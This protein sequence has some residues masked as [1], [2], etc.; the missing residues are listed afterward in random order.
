MFKFLLLTFLIIQTSFAGVGDIT[1]GQS[2]EVKKLLRKSHGIKGDK[3]HF[4][5]H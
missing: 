4:Q 2:K 5:R 3:I 1:G